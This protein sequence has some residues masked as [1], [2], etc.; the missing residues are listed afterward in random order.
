MFHIPSK[1]HLFG[2][3]SFETG[4]SVLASKGKKTSS[5]S[6]W[7]ESSFSLSC[8]QPIFA[9]EESVVAEG[10]TANFQLKKMRI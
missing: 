5:S 3:A 8:T 9:R 1:S 7:E 4:D 10:G 2:P 6:Q